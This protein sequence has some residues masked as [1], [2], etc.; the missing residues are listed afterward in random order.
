MCIN[1]ELCML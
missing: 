1:S